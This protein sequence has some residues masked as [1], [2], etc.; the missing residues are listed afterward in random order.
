MSSPSTADRLRNFLSETA[1]EEAREAQLCRT[2]LEKE[3]LSTAQLEDC[4]EER[5][6]RR[7]AG[8]KVRL[9]DVLVS[10]GVLT[11]QRFTDITGLQDVGLR[12]CLECGRVYDTAG[13]PPDV[14]LRCVKCGLELGHAPAS[15][16]KTT[17]GSG[18]RPA[19]QIPT[20]T[21]PR[22]GK[23][24]LTRE[25]GRGGVAVV[26]EAEDPELKRRVALK[27]LKENESTA[28]VIARL[29]RE[30][31]IVAQLSH[32]NI[33]AIHEVAMAR[34]A[35]GQSVHFIAMDYV[36]GTT[37]AH[38][39]AAK[40]T[41]LPELLRMLEDVTRAV[42]YA[43]GKGVIH[44][45]LKPSNVLVD[46]GGRVVL[47]DFG[48]AHTEM[49]G[50]KLTREQAV[51]GTPQY[52]APEQVQGKVS[53]VD[54]R[55][56]V[57]A[58]GVMLY[59]MLTGKMPFEAE[60]LVDLYRHILEDEPP[61]PSTSSREADEDLEALCLKAMEKR[62]ED[63][64]QDA[65]AFAEDLARHRRGE[66]VWA[67][68]VT[69][70]RRVKRRLRRN[71]NIVIQ[72][73]VAACLGILIGGYCVA[74]ITGAADPRGVPTI[75]LAA[76]V[77]V[78]LIAWIWRRSRSQKEHVAELARERA[79]VHADAGRSLLTRLDRLLST[80]EWTE[81]EVATLAESAREEF[82]AALREQPKNPEACLEMSRACRVEGRRDDALAWLDRAIATS[83]YFP[84]A[85]LE[86]AILRLEQYE[87]IRRDAC[88]HHRDT[89]EHGSAL[90]TEIENELKLVQG[91]TRERRE[92]MLAAGILALA[93]GHDEVAARQLGEYAKSTV[94][95][96][97]GWTW[98]GRAWM[99]L[100]GKEAEA[101][102]AFGEALK[103]RP[104]EVLALRL[105]AAARLRQS[106]LYGA[107][108]DTEAALRAKPADPALL[109]LR[110]IVREKRGDAAGAIADYDASLKAAESPESYLHRGHARLSAGRP[111]EALPDFGRALE[112]A[113]DLADAWE[114]RGAA[115]LAS[116]DAIGAADDLREAVKR[117]PH[118][119]I[120]RVRYAAALS[121]L[122]K[123][124]DA[125]RELEE[126]VR[127]APSLPDALLARSAARLAANDL[128]GAQADADAAIA[129]A[130]RSANAFSQRALVHLARGSHGPALADA[131]QALVFDPRNAVARARRG[132]AIRLRGGANANNDALEEFNAGLVIDP[133][134]GEALW[135]RGELLAA[136]G[137][138]DGA[139]ADL[140]QAMRGNTDPETRKRAEDVQRRLQG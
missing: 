55:T 53:E 96:P 103:F 27:V 114:A 108:E 93:D 99:K 101:V 32:P 106:D 115:K 90:R 140:N 30:A 42:S 49:F 23:Y 94:T 28:K 109:R 43:H 51:I 59:E 110:G 76:V 60:S 10:R 9:S 22:L 58:L 75:V 39:L 104:R 111:A 112:L 120:P 62:R 122:G 95:D 135:R 138:K 57:Y 34:D 66:A 2:A 85:H 71:K 26:H 21:R 118:S 78:V 37:L 83:E 127:R 136:I 139:R 63:R 38:V 35:M 134:C 50:T 129:S 107:L 91:H 65:H 121:A 69:G 19:V 6:R 133:N 126:A 98:A 105:R 44:R 15:A 100:P 80:K 89:G 84:T 88:G 11:P 70:W 5:D 18:I 68:P 12:V 137:D 73:S 40:R 132:A 54:G 45:D 130:P 81:P 123:S 67:Q 33:V 86:R 46:R 48:V 77:N 87:E 31:A 128:T 64:Y 52:M 7:A 116:G 56:D 3:F 16:K 29:H 36:E 14:K 124:D 119:A 25:I 13:Q 20:D 113:P 8:E 131:N 72:I 74:G 97:D 125:L 41:P 47:T 1:G 92:V 61:R 24:A 102:A 79:R 17:T 117:A 82:R 4:L